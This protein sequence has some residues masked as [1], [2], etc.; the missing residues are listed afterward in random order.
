MEN[1]VRLFFDAA[2]K[3]PDHFAIHS[4][5][6]SITYQELKDSVIR[7]ARYYE[8]KG[9]RK[10]SKVLVFIPMSI[11][12]YKTVLAL[13]A[14]GAVVVFIDEWANKKRFD[15]AL[16]IVKVDAVI[17]P[18]KYLFLGY[19][20]R[21]LRHIELS[22]VAPSDH[23]LMS[24]QRKSLFTEVDKQ[25]PASID[26]DDTALITFT[27]GS[28]GLPKAANRT[29]HFLNIQ[30][31]V[32]QEEMK[33]EASDCCLVT[34]PIVLLSILGT[35]GCAILP[36][37]NQRKPHLLNVPKQVKLL[38]KYKANTIIASPFYVG[39]LAESEYIF[40]DIQKVFTGGAPVFPDLAE[41][42][43]K[44]FPDANCQV[45]YGSTEAEPISMIAMN[46]VSLNQ[47]GLAVGSLNK[48]I[49]LKII[50]ITEEAIRLD[51]DGWHKWEVPFGEIVVS[52]PHVLKQYYNSK[53]AFHMNKIVD[54]ERIWH[55]TGDSGILIDGILYLNGRCSQ[56][57]NRDGTYHSL[58]IIEYQ[59]SQIPRVSLGT[60]MGE[61]VVLEVD[62]NNLRSSHLRKEIEN[63]VKS[64]KIPYQEIIFKRQI[65][66]D[67]RHHSK[68]DYGKL[69]E[70]IN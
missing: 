26:K 47:Y 30:F 14:I 18:R 29:H 13:L 59:I 17:A 8:E 67:P 23:K 39:R 55:R 36:Q 62:G 53:S 38:K 27:T 41:K 7:T 33:T 16:E 4:E 6:K 64:L 43:V 66:R 10:N 49:D 1:I 58:F 5:S 21:M 52:G 45:A 42:V 69:K 22:L 3:F 28:T 60:L 9:V 12:L 61:I 70:I 54:D 24:V 35:G 2:K 15:K 20:F 68:I 46:T 19:L 63:H 37:F 50:K 40:P 31:N 51:Q 48:H 32:L 56:L 11:R 44:A 34:L 25:S 65:P 57:L